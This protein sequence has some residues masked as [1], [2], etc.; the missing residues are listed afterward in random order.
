MPKACVKG[1]TYE[2]TH[3]LHLQTAC[4]PIK[5][6]ERAYVYIPCLEF[7]VEA[8]IVPG[9][10][11]ALSLGMLIGSGFSFEWD[12]QDEYAPKLTTPQG[13]SVFVWCEGQTPYISALE[14]DEGAPAAAAVLEDDEAIPGLPLTE[15][16]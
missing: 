15:L 2:A 1:D 3:G 6:K 7:R 8:V 12:P 16:E 4:G 10:C 14:Y 5:T 9:K 11:C 13:K